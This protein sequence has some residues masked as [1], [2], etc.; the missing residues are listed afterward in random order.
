[1]TARHREL[2]GITVFANLVYVQAALEEHRRIVATE[3]PKILMHANDCRDP[4]GCN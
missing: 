1:L 4:V 3:E 2:I